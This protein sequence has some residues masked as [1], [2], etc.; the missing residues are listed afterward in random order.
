M[1]TLIP[2]KWEYE[3]NPKDFYI[4]L[5]GFTKSSI[6]SFIKSENLEYLFNENFINNALEETNCPH[7]ETRLFN[8]L[9]NSKA[10]RA[11]EENEEYV[12]PVNFIWIHE[13]WTEKL[14]SYFTISDHILQ[15][16][17]S[18]KCKILIYSSW[19]APPLA[20]VKKFIHVIERKYSLSNANFIVLSNNINMILDS[21]EFNSHYQFPTALMNSGIYCIAVSFFQSLGTKNSNSVTAYDD[22][23]FEYIISSA[24]NDIKN[25]KKRN[26][27][28]ICLNRRSK[29]HRW[30]SAAYLFRDINDG[31]LS[32]TLN[33]GFDSIESFSYNE[34]DYLVNYKNHTYELLK[35]EET[36]YINSDYKLSLQ[37]FEYEL[38]KMHHGDL[39]KN[40]YVTTLSYITEILKSDEF[41]SQLPILI[42]DGVDVR[43]NPVHV[44]NIENFFDSYLHI[45]T[46]TECHTDYKYWLTEKIYKPIWFLQPFVCIGFFQ[47]LKF[48]R[49][50][51][52]KT[53]GEWIDESYDDIEDPNERT[54]AALNSARKFYNRD[55]DSILD[56][57]EKMLE[58]LI[59]NRNKLI[60]NNKNFH[61]L[62]T[63]NILKAFG[64]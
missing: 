60:E 49:G 10:F 14:A 50:L 20:V 43:S 4:G 41:V 21:P 8:D 64:R 52:F 51:G 13:R 9:E 59:Y 27:K 23:N 45:V 11:P 63:E 2:A 12:Y 44:S 55:H 29:L 62:V 36:N 53:F 33:N 19:E 15:D 26:Y 31:L 47:S 46:E 35:S 37:Q 7:F 42:N 24:I 61:Q 18:K 6:I 57:Y 1:T 30:M 25:K 58:T 16:I 3:S 48:L 22:E 17:K 38:S 34:E 5:N 39:E 54:I 56:D 40:E 32:F 28:F